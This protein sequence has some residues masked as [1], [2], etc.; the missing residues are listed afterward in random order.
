[1]ETARRSAFKQPRKPTGH[2][3]GSPTQLAIL[4]LLR[5]YRY[6]PSTYIKALI[7]AGAEYVEN[8]LPDLVEKHY[9][10]IPEKAVDRCKTRQV[11]YV[12]ELLPRGVTFLAQ[13][14]RPTSRSLAS[15][16]FSH[17]VLACT[18]QASFDL[19]PTVIPGLLK[20]TPQ[21]ILAHENC[22]PRTKESLTPFVIDTKPVLEADADPFGFEYNSK[23]IFFHGFEADNGTETIITTVKN[24]IERYCEYFERKLPTK[25][26]GMGKDHVHILFVTINEDRARHMA[27]HVPKEWADRFHFK[28][29]SGFDTT[30]PPPTAHMV[31]DPWIQKGGK[32]WSILEHLGV[33]YDTPRDSGEGRQ[34]IGGNQREGSRAGRVA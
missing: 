2:L 18:I 27:E 28:A 4:E 29:T 23:L 1:M 14:G 34:A 5:D 31:L 22:P 12:Y 24:K 9:I 19:A 6:L 3:T 10:G 30:F 21:A 17:D 32:T 25:M 15:N 20:R 13:N 26:F 11:P 7:P 33:S 16:W 8:V